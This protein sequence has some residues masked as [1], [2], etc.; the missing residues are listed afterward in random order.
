METQKTVNL[1]NDSNSE[2]SKFATKEWC[3]IDSETT[4]TYKKEDP[5]NFITDSVKSIKP[6]RLF[7]WYI[8]VKVNIAVTNGNTNTKVAF[9][10]CPPFKTCQTE[11]YDVFV[12]DFHYI[13][14]AILMYNLIEYSNN[15]SDTSGSLWKFKRDEINCNADVTTA[16]S[17]LFKDKWNLIGN[18]KSDGTVEGVK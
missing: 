2:S 4:G 7:W 6:L 8:I 3:V 14:I 10:N 1:L 17:S 18:L 5:V 11:I 16:N 13:F 15:Y 12:D 9:K